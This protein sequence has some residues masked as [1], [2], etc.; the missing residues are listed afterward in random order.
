MQRSWPPVRK[1]PVTPCMTRWRRPTPMAWRS[2]R[3]LEPAWGCPLDPEAHP[4]ST[5]HQLRG[6]LAAPAL[7][8]PSHWMRRPCGAEPEAEIAQSHG[9]GTAASTRHLGAHGAGARSNAAASAADMRA[10]QPVD[11]PATLARLDLPEPQQTQMLEQLLC[12][13]R[14]GARCRG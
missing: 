7:P 14:A 6:T 11:L 9:R 3:R 10:G 2:A 12:G 1:R 5:Q 4:L 13:C 8:R